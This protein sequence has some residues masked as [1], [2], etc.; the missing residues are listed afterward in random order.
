M[1]I[2]PTET[3]YTLSVKRHNGESLYHGKDRMTL[4][5]S[6]LEDLYERD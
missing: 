5:A 6:A 4:I 3:G 1:T 2:T